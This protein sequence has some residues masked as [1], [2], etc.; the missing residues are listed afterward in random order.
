MDVGFGGTVTAPPVHIWL[1]VLDLNFS[2][3]AVFALPV[4]DLGWDD[5]PQLQQG[6][7]GHHDDHLLSGKKGGMLL[8]EM[9]AAH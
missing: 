1:L 8:P 6:D 3:K 4:V 9:L 7:G 5:P 2:P